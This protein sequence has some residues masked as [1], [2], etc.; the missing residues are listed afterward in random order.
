MF[1]SLIYS[2]RGYTTM[3]E[4]EIDRNLIRVPKSSSYSEKN[5]YLL[6]RFTPETEFAPVGSLYLRLRYPLEVRVAK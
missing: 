6:Y 2:P 4:E 5:T 3:T 1:R